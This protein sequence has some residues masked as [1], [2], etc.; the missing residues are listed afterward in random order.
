MKNLK[1]L[2]DGVVILGKSH[3]PGE[4]VPNVDNGTAAKLIAG[5]SAEIH[6]DSRGVKKITPSKAPKVLKAPKVPKDK[7]VDAAP[8]A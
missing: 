3:S 8:E 7:P 4:I 2:A 5:K 1:I 6:V